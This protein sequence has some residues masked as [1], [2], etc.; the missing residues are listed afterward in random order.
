MKVRLPS[1]GFGGHQ[2]FTS[3][4]PSV[5]WQLPPAMKFQSKGNWIFGLG[6]KKNFG[7]DGTNLSV[8]AK[9]RGEFKLKHLFRRTP[10]AAAKKEQKA[11][12]DSGRRDGAGNPR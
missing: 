12:G 7:P 1:G 2:Q 3:I 10:E 5:L 6:L 8:S 11:A 4:N 9:L